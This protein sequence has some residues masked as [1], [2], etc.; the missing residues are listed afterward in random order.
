MRLPAPRPATPSSA[1]KPS[2]FSQPSAPAPAFDGA[3]ADPVGAGRAAGAGCRALKCHVACGHVADE[4]DAKGGSASAGGGRNELTPIEQ[5][6]PGC[7]TPPLTHAVWPA[8]TV[9]LLKLAPVRCWDLPPDF[10]A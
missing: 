7:I 8:A 4:G 5:L 1:S 10:Q 9:A 3:F 6:A 2:R